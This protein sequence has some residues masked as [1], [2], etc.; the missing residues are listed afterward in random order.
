MVLHSPQRL[1]DR[2]E[3]A[4]LFGST[5]VKRFRLSVQLIA[6]NKI[7]VPIDGITDCNRSDSCKFKVDLNWSKSLAREARRN[8]L[9]NN[10]EQKIYL[11]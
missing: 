11:T 1:C 9:Y 6:H 3:E 2:F 10:V 4:I 5:H 8:Y 7:S